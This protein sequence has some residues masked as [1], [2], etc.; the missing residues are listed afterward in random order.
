MDLEA[1]RAIID[2]ILHNVTL[3]TLKL[4]NN[5]GDSQIYRSLR[6]IYAHNY[7]L[8]LE[9]EGK[10]QGSSL[11]KIESSKHLTWSVG[12]GVFYSVTLISTIGYGTIACN[13]SVGRILSILY[14][15]VGIPLM[16]VV[17]KDIGDLFHAF[18]SRIYVRIVVKLSDKI[19]LT[20]HITEACYCFLRERQIVNRRAFFRRMKIDLSDKKS[21]DVKL[22]MAVS[23]P[24]LFI[25]MIICALAVEYFD[26]AEGVNKG[27][28]FKK[29][30]YFAFISLS[31][32]G[33]G[34]VM[35]TKIHYSPLVAMMFLFGLSL[36]SVVNTSAYLRME[37]GFLF[38]IRRAE[39]ALERIHKEQHARRGYKIFQVK[40]H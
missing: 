8:L 14:A 4:T 37:D 21:R 27:L 9:A 32:I 17:I 30:F 25:Y 39:G 2:E 1:T 6:R 29:S 31:T 16:L 40:S 12:S 34:D 23:V 19:G 13:T 10:L 22:P 11:H 38:A 7:R 3:V 24:I 26:D 5:E 20:F 28:D 18:F 35:P 33:L 15:T 36:V